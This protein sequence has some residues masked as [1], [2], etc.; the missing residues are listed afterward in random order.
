MT[1]DKF[2]TVVRELVTQ[3]SRVA[4]AAEAIATVLG[5]PSVR[6]VC[7]CCGS[8]LVAPDQPITTCPACR[9]ENAR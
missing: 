8:T 3:M 9:T 4:H 6:E 7:R 2:E 5:A 1:M